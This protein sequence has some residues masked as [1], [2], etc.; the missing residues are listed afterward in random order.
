MVRVGRAT[1]GLVQGDI[2]DQ[3]VDAIVNAAND[4]LWMGAGVAGA[5]RVKGVALVFANAFRIWLRDDT[6]DMAKT[7]AALDAG[8][9]RAESMAVFCGLA[10]RDERARRDPSTGA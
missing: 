8:L 4:C 3:D 5:M 2:T 6:E 7:M 10:R 9:Q 1:V